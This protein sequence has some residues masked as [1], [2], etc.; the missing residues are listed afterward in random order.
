MRTKTFTFL[1]AFLISATTLFSQEKEVNKDGNYKGVIRIKIENS[2]VKQF[3][4]LH[5]KK[6]HTTNKVTQ[7]EKGYVKTNIQALDAKN[8]EFGA[9]EYKRVFRDAGKF[10]KRHRAFGL[11]KWYEITFDSKAEVDQLVKEYNKIKEVDIA[12][13]VPEMQLFDKDPHKKTTKATKTL[14]GG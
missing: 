2:L 7:S 13:A 4:E 3:D 14:T 11:H 6:N 9:K 5:K 10:E 1:M 12:E 8:A